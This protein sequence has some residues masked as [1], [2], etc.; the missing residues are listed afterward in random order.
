[1][2]W[3]GTIVLAVV[4]LIAGAYLWVAEAPKPLSPENPPSLLGEPLL[5]DPSKFVALIPFKPGDVEALE[6]RHGQAHLT[7]TRTA[8]G[9]QS[10]PDQAPIDAFLNN[11]T[12]LGRVMQIPATANALQDYGLEAP[13]SVVKLRL[14]G[15]DRPL[16]VE[17]GD[18]NPA[19]TG[20]YVRIDG[21]GP[22]IL[23]GALLTWELDKL[24]RRFQE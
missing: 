15:T 20:V 12:E 4:V 8:E 18:Q 7:A 1:M 19:G 22:V 16:T 21:Q 10:S 23:A 3:R 17:I 11:L 13:Q 24:F 9:W 2:G 5:R 6:V 14:R